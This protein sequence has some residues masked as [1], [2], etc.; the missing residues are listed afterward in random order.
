MSKD[1]TPIRII[2]TTRDQESIKGLK[3][4][5]EEDIDGEQ[6]LSPTSRLFHEPGV[7]VY[8]VVII[9]MK[10]FINVE[11]FKSYA[12]VLKD[13]NCRFSSLQVLNKEN[14]SM[15]WV[16]INVDI[17]NHVVVPE[18]DPNL[19]SS[20]IYVE[21]YVSN[22]SRSHIESSKPLWDVHILNTKTTYANGICIF[23]FHHSIGDG[24]SLMNLLLAFSGK[25]SNPEELPTLYGEKA[26][27][28]RIQITCSRSL[29]TILWNSIVALVMFMLTAVFLKD[30]KT[31]I[32]G[33]PG[34]E[35]TPRRFVHRIVSFEDI[36][37]TKR[38]MNVTVN[39]VILGV[40]Q[41]G[42]YRYLKWRYEN[43]DIVSESIRL[44]AAL[45]FNL[46][47]TTRV[48]PF[49]DDTSKHGTWGNDIGYVLLPFNIRYRKDVLDYVREARAS[50]E[51]KKA[52]LEPFC[53][54]FL[55]KLVI[56][57]FGVKVS[58]KLNYNVLSNVTL[59]Y[60]SLPG[61]QE[62]IILFGHEVAY[63]APSCYGQPM[64]LAIHAVSYVD[65]VTFMISVDEEIIPDP[66]TLCDDIQQSLHLIKSSLA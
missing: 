49:G 51:R 43:D 12:K 48:N 4:I 52:S 13:K 15:T 50:M 17:N 63:I 27:P 34:I 23:R 33:N 38:A 2:K 19:D 10:T 11:V 31:P 21:D 3:N 64:A 28:H 6:P 60:S 26:S 36:K 59:G 44:R 40:V 7:N 35:G 30:T 56:K 24:I 53:T 9:G 65:K 37:S 62:E 8:I 14:G 42:L 57:L 16:P 45:F 32:K 29:L 55:A 39:D 5:C 41:A 18:L 66:Q 58:G 47:A 46:R 25:A 54:S 1:P 61:P 22:L 20:D